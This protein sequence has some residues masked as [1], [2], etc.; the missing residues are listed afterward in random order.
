MVEDMVR[1]GL[2]TRE[3]LVDSPFAH[4][5]SRAVGSQPVVQVDTLSFEALLGDRFVLCSDG[6]SNHLEAAADLLP[7]V[8][9]DLDDAGLEA[10]AEALVQKANDGGG[11]DNITVVIA[12]V[13]GEISPGRAEAVESRYQALHS[14]F[15]FSQL[16]RAMV[17]RVLSVCTVETHDE[18][19]CVIEQGAEAGALLVV[20]NGRYALRNDAEDGG[21]LGPGDYAGATTLIKPR[22]S[23]A[24]LVAL[25]P[26]RLLRLTGE[27]FSRLIRTRP[28]LGIF[29]L[30]R[31]GN[32]LSADLDRSYL[33]R[34]GES[35]E[36]VRIRERF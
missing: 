25:E 21:E 20:V 18:G 8:G 17:A 35:G 15:M 28:W 16:D 10:A 34:E 11:G 30:E 2:A 29:L 36:E 13:Q 9:A 12:K 5:L 22:P 7:T 19:A 4:V 1:T 31:L 6:F 33:Q 27:A 3:D 32:K 23:R 26:S 24:T 14:M